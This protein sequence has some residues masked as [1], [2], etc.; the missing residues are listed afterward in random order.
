MDVPAAK[1][2]CLNHPG[3]GNSSQGDG[4]TSR[5]GSGDGGSRSRL[6]RTARHKTTCNARKLRRV[7]PSL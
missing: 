6:P 7:V 5:H 2:V 4:G 1:E 3:D